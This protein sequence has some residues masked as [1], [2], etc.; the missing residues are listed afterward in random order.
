MTDK[1]ALSTRGRALEEQ[2]FHK[3][4]LE[5]IEKLRRRGQDERERRRL[6]EGTGVA[7]EEILQDLLA[8][9]YTPETVMLLHVVPLVQIAWAE[10][11]VSKSERRLIVEAARAR[12]VA[13]GSA[14]DQVLAQWLERRPSDEFFEKTLRA[15]AAML[16]AQPDDVRQ[17]SQHD[18]LG[19]CSAIAHASGGVL[20]FGSVTP[21]ER[22]TLAKITQVLE[23]RQMA[24]AGENDPTGQDS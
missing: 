16:H 14:A 24:R 6:S 19:Y 3:Q 10:G 9:G 13:A 18:L 8:L 20:G 23:S 22:E 4:E 12:G 5:L 1:D 17:A 15:V 21:D 2:Y 7:D 11:S